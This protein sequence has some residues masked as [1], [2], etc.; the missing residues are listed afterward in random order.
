[1]ARKVKTR[2]PEAGPSNSVSV[3]ARTVENRKGAAPKEKRGEE[4]PT[5]RKLREG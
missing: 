4:V 2:A 5:L 3:T 1:M